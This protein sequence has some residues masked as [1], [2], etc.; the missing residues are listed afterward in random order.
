MSLSLG[1]LRGLVDTSLGD[2][3]LQTYLNAAYEAIDQRLPPDSPVTELF[4]VGGDRLML[5]RPAESVTT[6]IE[7]TGFN[8]TTLGSSDYELMPSG[9]TLLRLHTGSSPAWRWRGRVRVQ[10]DP[11]SAQNLRDSVAAQLVKLDVNTQHGITQ[12]SLGSFSESYGQG[13]ASYDAQRESILS[14]LNPTGVLL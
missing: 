12:Q 3:S 7:W 6:V 13:G 1:E 2:T 14:T 10:Y 8:P 5:S 9:Q 11:K 4:A